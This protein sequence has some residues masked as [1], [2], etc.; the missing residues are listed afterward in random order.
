MSSLAPSLLNLMSGRPSEK[1]MPKVT[2]PA[3]FW[4]DNGKHLPAVQQM[5]HDLLAIPVMSSEVERVFS[6]ARNI[7]D[8][9]RIRLGAAIFEMTE[10]EKQWMRA[11]LGDDLGL[12]GDLTG[13]LT[14][15]GKAVLEKML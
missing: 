15:D 5:A 10:L 7:M 2:D 13:Y 14:P 1:T 3:F 9:H 8:D 4:R 12:S 6:S 11:G